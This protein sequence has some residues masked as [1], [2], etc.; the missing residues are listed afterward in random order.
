MLIEQLQQEKIIDKLTQ[1]PFQEG[2]VF[3]LLIATESAEA[4][5]DLIAS[6]QRKQIPF[7][8]AIFPGLI[9]GKR[10]IKEG[11][12]IKKWKTA[13]PPVIIKGLASKQLEGFENLHVPEG[14]YKLTAF[15]FVDGLTYHI[16]NLLEKLNNL[17]GDRLNFIG[18]GAGTMSFQNQVCVFSNEGFFEDA[19]V[20]CLVDHKVQLGVRHGWEKI[21]GPLVATQTEHNI[22]C[23]LNWENA[24]EVYKAIVEADS[25]QE[26]RHD[27]FFEMAKNYPF[28]IYRE[29]E[30]DIVRDPFKMN[31]KGELVCFGEIKPHTVLNI[32]KGKPATLID[33]AQHAL[34]DCKGT[35]T[36]PI[37]AAETMV[38]NCISRR[39]FLGDSFYD[40]IAIIADEIDREN[41]QVPHGILSL[42]E[43]SSY[44]TGLLDVFN[45]TIVVGT[46]IH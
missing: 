25:G 40:E 34:N 36:G 19:A 33:A 5:Q 3:M 18:G 22:I 26:I 20:I 43:I 28:G 14:N 31:E 12:I 46:F 41:E 39:H 6:L 23:Q 45:K 15:T 44:G 1:M 32:L 2:E 9:H 17:Y 7:F 42:G 8:G 13:G 29:N 27:N 16:D 10:E 35:Q 4:V 30:E 37:Q 38:V 21:A 11:V 24:F